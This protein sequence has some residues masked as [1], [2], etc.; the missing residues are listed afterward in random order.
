M[1][2]LRKPTMLVTS[3]PKRWNSC[4]TGSAIAQPTPP[5]TIQTFLM[6]SVSV[7]L[8]RG[9]TK[10]SIYSPSCLWLS[11]AVVEPTIWKM[12]FTVPSSRLQPATVNGIRSPSA[13][14]RRMM[15]CPGFA[16][17][18]TNGASISICVTVG[19][20]SFFLTILYISIIICLITNN[21]QKTMFSIQYVYK[22]RTYF[23]TKTFFI[24][25]F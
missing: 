18:A 11:L 19:F 23:I 21:L 7:A 12:I 17:L 10:S 20:S 16:F 25:Y 5:P 4:A 9:P 8:P 6:P 14:T 13:S 1:S 15:N 3:T 24:E 22:Y 2:L